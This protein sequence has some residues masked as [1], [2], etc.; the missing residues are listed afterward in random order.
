MAIE[1]RMRGHQRPG[2]R[3]ACGMRASNTTTRPGRGTTARAD[4]GAGLVVED[5]LAL[6]FR[7]PLGMDV[8]Q[9]RQPARRVAID[10]D[11][12]RLGGDLA[13]GVAIVDLVRALQYGR[14]ERVE[15]CGDRRVLRDLLA[16]AP[17]RKPKER[18]RIV[19]VGFVAEL[20]EQHVGELGQFALKRRRNQIVV[21]VEA[22]NGA[23]LAD[24]M[25]DLKSGDRGVGRGRWVNSPIPGRPAARCARSRARPRGDRRPSALA[26]IDGAGGACRAAVSDGDVVRGGDFGGRDVLEA[27]SAISGGGPAVELASP[28]G[29]EPLFLP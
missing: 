26:D 24:P 17:E 12:A 27:P 4:L 15:Q 23:M 19:R 7:A 28:R 13:V 25:P 1:A 20:P 29:F 10:M 16:R 11:M 8:G 5:R 18:R 6:P 2:G 3:P 21:N 14:V 9:R 22:H